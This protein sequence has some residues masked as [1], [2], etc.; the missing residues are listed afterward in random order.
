MYGSLH[1]QEGIKVVD[2]LYKTA[3]TINP[4]QSTEHAIGQFSADAGTILPYRW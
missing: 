3:N 4:G 2:M 1:F